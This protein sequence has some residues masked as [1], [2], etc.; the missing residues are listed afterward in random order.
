M[1]VDRKTNFAFKSGILVLILAIVLGA[2][3]AHGLKGKLSPEKLISF[4]T[5]VRY[6]FYCAFGLII[7][8]LSSIV[9][10]IKLRFSAT[11]LFIG[12]LAFS[13]S[14]YGLSVN[15]LFQ[16]GLSKILG[17]IT[18]IGGLLMILSWV[19]LYVEYIKSSTTVVERECQE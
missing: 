18:P 13:G 1:I 10:Q 7:M 4:E 17:P 15:E 6:Q 3:A 9:L 12:F 19:F 11:L 5:G 8:A 14:I 2:F 16:L